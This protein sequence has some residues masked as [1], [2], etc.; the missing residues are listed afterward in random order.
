MS[1]F[2]QLAQVRGKIFSKQ[3]Y[4]GPLWK[5]TSTLCSLVWIVFE[6]LM[7]VK[8]YI[9]VL[10]LFIQLATLNYCYLLKNGG[11]PMH[12]LTESARNGTWLA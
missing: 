6:G 1:R 5:G 8:L 11:L 9:I 7:K 3:K 10:Y 12:S 4:K 2:Q